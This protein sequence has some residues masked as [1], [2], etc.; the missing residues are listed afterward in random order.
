MKLA[1]SMK[2][3]YIITEKNDA[4]IFRHNRESNSRTLGYCAGTLFIKLS[5]A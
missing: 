3:K 4:Q 5:L 1:S 2:S